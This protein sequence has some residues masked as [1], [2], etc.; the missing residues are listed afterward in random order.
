MHHQFARPCSRPAPAAIAAVLALVTPLLVFVTAAPAHAAGAVT[1]SVS[2]KG[3]VSGPGIICNESGGP[4]CSESY[5]D[6]RECD[7]AET[8]PICWNSPPD[9][10]LTAGGDRSGYAFQRWDGCDPPDSGRTCHLTVDSARHP[11]ARF[12]DVQA[13]AV[14]GLSPGSGVQRGTITTSV[15]ASDN[16]GTVARVEFRLRGVLVATDTSAPYS[17]S[18]N[19]LTMADGPAELRA[20]AYDQAGHSSFTAASLTIDNTAPTVAVTGGPDHGVFSTGSTQTWTFEASDT[21]SGVAAVQCSVVPVGSPPSFGACSGGSTSHSVDNRPPGSYEFTVQA[22]DQGG[23]TSTASRRFTVDGTPP[24]LVVASGPEDGS[25]QR[26]G[27]QTWGLEA[28]DDHGTPA[29]TCGVA[30]RGT[31]PA[32][33]PCSGGDSHTSGPLEGGSWTFTAR[34][35]DGVGHV[36]TTT[37]S[38]VV[39]ALRPRVGKVAPRA[40]SRTRDRTPLVKA[41]LRDEV[42]PGVAGTVRAGDVRL[43]VDRRRRPFTLDGSR[44]A[45]QAGRLSPGSHT[46]KLVVA[47]EA[48]NRT[49]KSWWFTVRR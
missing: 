5:P 1:V 4:D 7:D 6:V 32:L 41:V 46:V 27:A 22:R 17:A 43:L 11:T 37:R 24:T 9:V 14:T 3:D 47:D 40:R 28:T 36:T 8:P 34:A 26:P 19:T 33:G 31:V 25:L 42:L 15:G 16:S 13:P 39:D 10:T 21:T 45:W 30:A 29:V 48:G 18:V 35:E 23:L 2:G 49:R 38:F 20:T 44:L 12:S